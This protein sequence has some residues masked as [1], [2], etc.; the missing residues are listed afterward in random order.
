MPVR[1]LSMFLD[2]VHSVA[3]DLPIEALPLSGLVSLSDGR[4]L[5]DLPGEAVGIDLAI[6]SPPYPNNIDYTEVYKLEAWLLGLYPEHSDF[7]SQRLRTVRSHP[8]V[9]YEDVY[10]YES[11]P[12]AEDVSELLAPLIGAI[13]KGDRYTN[14]RTQVVRGYFDDML[15]TLFAVYDRL[16]PGGHLVYVVGNSLHGSPRHRLLIAADL[17]IARLAE[18]AGLQVECLQIARLPQR[19]SNVTRYLRESIVF[20]R[21]PPATKE[22]E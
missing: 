18:I 6:F 21:R 8:S 22:G 17:V 20:C 10:Q 1:P 14:G 15:R 7:R 4:S 19:R 11:S 16:R 12:H 13:P 9:R 3:E 5:K 2:S